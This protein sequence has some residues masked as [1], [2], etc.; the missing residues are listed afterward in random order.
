MRNYLEFLEYLS[1][2]GLGWV[3]FLIAAIGDFV[4]PFFLGLFVRR[5]SHVYMLTDE[6]GET[7]S[8]V[9]SIYSRWLAFAGLLFL[10][11]APQFY[12]AYNATDAVLSMSVAVCIAVDGVAAL[13]CAFSPAGTGGEPETA[14]EWT[15]SIAAAVG[16]IARLGGLLPLSLVQFQQGQTGSGSMSIVCFMVCVTLCALFVLSDKDRF[17]ATPVAWKGLWQRLLI[18]AAYIPYAATAAL[19]LRL[20]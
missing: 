17:A 19:Y 18:L 14:G 15:H 6:L 2:P 3:L 9:R 4:L 10:C 8:P 12:Y 11:A 20:L 13:L 1:A 5:F 16:G 7:G